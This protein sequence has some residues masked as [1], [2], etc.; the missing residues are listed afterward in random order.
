MMS[1]SSSS[2]PSAAADSSDKASS[3][4]PASC[5]APAASSARRARAPG[6]TRERG[7][8]L[9][10]RRG[11]RQPAARLRPPGGALQLLGDVLVG[12]DGGLRA[13]PGVTIGVE[14]GVGGRRQRPMHGSPILGRCRPV[15]RRAQQRVAEDDPR[16][17]VEQAVTHGGIHGL[18][19]EPEL[20]RRSP[21]ERRFA[22]RLG[23]RQQQQPLS[24]RRQLLHA[25]PEARLDP[26]LQRKLTRKAEA[27]GQL[28]G[29]QRARAARATR[30]GCR[31]T[32]RGSRARTRSSSGVLTTD[33]SSSR[34][35][36]SESPSSRMS[37]SR[38]SSSSASGSR[39]A[40]ASTTASAFR[41]RATNEITCADDRSSHW[42]SSTRHSSGCSPA[43]SDSRLSVARL[44]RKRSGWAPAVSPNAVPSASRCGAGNR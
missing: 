41:R 33:A 32:R 44:I 35:C 1:S 10:E 24:R 26:A 23:G 4:A 2:G 19:R 28:R 39:I 20:R 36:A 30:A 6:S 31:G 13:V 16:P 11:R 5:L 3:G 17:E 22:G 7:R 37:G 38:T 21:Q 34:A 15:D 18:D 27:A 14:R 12:A 40:N 43:A 8:A 42:A 29:R 25:A 9:E